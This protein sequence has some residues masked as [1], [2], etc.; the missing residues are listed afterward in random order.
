MHVSERITNVAL[1]IS[2]LLAGG[3]FAMRLK[4]RSNQPRGLE[5]VRNWKAYGEE[6]P[7]IG[8]PEARVTVVVFSDFQCPFCR[9]FA[10]TVALAQ[11]KQPNA[12]RM[13]FRHFPLRR[14]HPFA[15]AAAQAAVCADRQGRFAQL[16][17]LLFSLQDSL[18][19]IPL[20]ALAR[21]AGVVDVETFGKCV[22][23]R[24]T[25]ATI[26]RDSAAAMTLKI[27]GTPLV[28]VNE[29]LVPWTPSE[30]L[31]DSLV[32]RVPPE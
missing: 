23:D 27:G 9:Q 18:G 30:A 19:T 7:V 32:R 3:A 25:Q 15:V 11:Q 13:V 21:R 2:V 1:L 4:E 28:L 31:L 24:A 16:H 20:E 17:D 8:S 29:V 10:Q 22:A 6:G 5:V 26:T 12:I 14:I